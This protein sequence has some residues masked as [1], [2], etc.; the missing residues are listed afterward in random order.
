MPDE[1]GDQFFLHYGNKN[2]Y[3][4]FVA[5]VKRPFG[6]LVSALG[7]RPET[8]WMKLEPRG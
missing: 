1:Y 8:I 3:R 5:S 2:F 4:H 6:T 7:T